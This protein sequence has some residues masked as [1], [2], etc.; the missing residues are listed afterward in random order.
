[1]ASI[2]VARLSAQLDHASSVVALLVELAMD[3]AVCA[4]DSVVWMHVQEACGL[5]RNASGG[6]AC[7]QVH[8]RL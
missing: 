8:Q 5:M 6:W 2:E 4:E 3:T 7:D 1:M